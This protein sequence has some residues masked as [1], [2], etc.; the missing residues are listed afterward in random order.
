MSRPFPATRARHWRGLGTAGALA[1]GVLATGALAACGSHHQPSAAPATTLPSTTTT[2]TT[3]PPPA[4]RAPLTG[5][6]AT[7][8]TL[9][10]VAVVV[11][12]DN[13][14]AALPQTGVQQADVVYEEMVEGGL[15]RLAAVYQSDYPR[16]VGPVRSG[17]L[18]DEGIADD[19][20]HPVLAYAG[21]N[22]LFQPQLAAQPLHV[23]DDDEYPGLYQR[24][25]SREAPH[26]LYS[27]VASLAKTVAKPTAPSPLW[28]F[29]PAGQPF[30]GAGVSPAKRV[31]ISFPAA[32]ITWTWVP[33][34]RLW[35]RTQD[36]VADVDTSGGRLTA[37][38]VIVEAV[39]YVTSA[40]VTGEG[41]G[42]NGAPIPTGEMVGS[43]KAWFLSGGALVEGSWHRASLTSKTVY[44]D[45]AGKPIRLAPGRT[46]VE[47]PP[48][49]AAVIVQ[50]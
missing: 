44:V 7:T 21:A 41:A 12:I 42:A 27:D 5:L 36:G 19:L 50:R 34:Q 46:W 43:G 48:E 45:R 37:T 23:A 17:R 40:Y 18:T 26:N 14:A 11:K 32:A 10:H 1:A 29:H 4:P 39:N 35:F 16:V 8:A 33:K 24:N 25:Y 13:V 31:S 49:G 22:P 3:T 15:T 20:D 47:L 9:R 2:T 6:P 28:A 38:N 30:A